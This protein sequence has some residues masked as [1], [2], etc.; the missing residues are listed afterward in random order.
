L[1]VSLRNSFE[2]VVFG[3]HPELAQVKVLMLA[4]GADAAL[5]SGSGSALFAIV[6]GRNAKTVKRALEQKQIP[7]LSLTTIA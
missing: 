7:F 1:N 3:R 5:L 6:H 4:A 2:D